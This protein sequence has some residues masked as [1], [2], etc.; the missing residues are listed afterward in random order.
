MLAYVN[1]S[2]DRSVAKSSDGDD[3]QGGRY[4]DAQLHAHACIVCGTEDGP[5]QRNGHVKVESRPGQS[6]AWAVV[7]CPAHW[8]RPVC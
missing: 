4:T 5:L 2:R 1:T 6:L 3:A 8:G 7:A